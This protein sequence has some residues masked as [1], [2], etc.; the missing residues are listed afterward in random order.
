[1]AFKLPRLPRNT[2]LVDRNGYP[3]QAFQMWWQ[4]FATNIESEVGALE[5]ADA[6]QAAATAANAAAAAANAAA[7][8]AQ[9]AA[10]DITTEANLVNS[11]VT[12]LTLGATDAGASASISISAHS[13]VYGNGATVSVNSGNLTGLSYST[14]YY[15]YY[16]QAS[17]AGGAVTYAST[18]NE[19]TSAQT[20]NRHFVGVITTPAAAAGPT[21]GYGVS[22]PGIGSVYIP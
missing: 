7:A 4:T 22:P 14:A 15:I 16:D 18:T 8:T 19:A 2:A 10:D 1:M 6:A 9:T 5:A 11:Y 20:G 17:R 3:T 21:S 12:G 13:R